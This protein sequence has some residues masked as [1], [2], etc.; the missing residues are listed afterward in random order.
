MDIKRYSIP[1]TRDPFVNTPFVR[2][3]VDPE[4]GDERFWCSSWNANV[5]CIGVLV[6]SGGKGRVYRFAKGKGYAGCG[7]YS[8]IYVGDEKMWLISDTSCIRRLDLT[9]GDVEEFETGAKQGL[10]FAGMQYDEKT[11]KLAFFSHPYDKSGLLGVCFDTK[12]CKTV[13]LWEKFT[14]ST[15]AVGGCVNPDGTHTFRFTVVAPSLWRWDPETDELTKAYDFPAD[16]V[17]NLSPLSGEKGHYM[18]GLGWFDGYTV[19]PNDPAPERDMEWFGRCGNL[20]YGVMG[21]T[22][23]RWN[24]ETGEVV[25][26]FEKISD[27]MCILDKNGNILT[28]GRFAQFCKYAP[29]GAILISK[30]FDASTYGHVDCIAPTDDGKIVGTPFITQRFW[31]FDEVTGIGYDAGK[32]APG[33][34]QVAKIWNHSGK[35]YL[36]S[37]TGATLTE[38]DPKKPANYPE[39]PIL[40]AKA[41]TGMRPVADAADD[42]YIYYSSNHHYGHIGCILTKFDTVTG[43]SLYRDDPLVN[44][45]IISLY[46]S[47]DALWAGT[48]WQSD[49]RASVE[50]DKESYLLRIDPDTLEVT[51]KYLAPT[52]VDHVHVYGEIDG[53]LLITHRGATVGKFLRF[54]PEL[55]AVMDLYDI[56][57]KTHMIARAGDKYILLRDG[58]IERWSLGKEAV[59]EAVL[60]EDADVYNVFCHTAAGKLVLCAAKQKEFYVIRDFA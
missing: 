42:R 21:D 17:P 59:C 40:V 24:M 11:G 20:A 31:V 43:E 44:Q 39:N 23:Y 58:K 27:S 33:G 28:F 30:Q 6:S 18:Q 47:K 38:F 8:A 19:T 5:G 35:I 53:D 15:S 26:L 34:G 22:I 2:A 13:R 55:G 14:E 10:V 57:E 48:T 32:A 49:C 12:T 50:P 7:A 9:T 46:R 56:P 54:M 3:G 16:C 1:M 41:P 60:L 51:D 37:Y 25:R 52:D 29:D 36:A 45:Q 4:T